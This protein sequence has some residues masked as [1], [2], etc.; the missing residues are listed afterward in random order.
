MDHDPVASI[1]T[2]PAIALRGLT[3]FP[4]VLIHF[5]VGRAA[6]IKAMEAAMAAGEPVFL[7]GQKDMTVERPERDDLYTVGTLSNVRADPPHARGQRACDGGGHLPGPPE[8]RD[9]EGALFDGGD[10]SH[11]RGEG[12][13]GLG[14]DRG[15]D[16]QHL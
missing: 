14:Q 5:D 6:S 1:Q 9:P 4:N 16:A 2:L 10:R 7:V 3:V 11:P 15:P 8:G 12:G 13:Q